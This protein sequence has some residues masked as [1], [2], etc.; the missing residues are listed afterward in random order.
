M[1]VKTS[2]YETIEGENERYS[3]SEQERGLADSGVSN[4][5]HFEEVIAMMGRLG[6]GKL[7]ILRSYLFVVFEIIIIEKSNSDK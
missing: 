7:T 3:K 4:Q 6:R 5:E 2:S 1:S